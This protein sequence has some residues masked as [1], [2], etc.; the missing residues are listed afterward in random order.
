MAVIVLSHVCAAT[1]AAI[2]PA[3]D[4]HR[5]TLE[6]GS[7]G[8]FAEA[9]RLVL[10]ALAADPQHIPSRRVQDLLADERVGF[11]EDDAATLL[12]KGLALQA[13][14]DW[15]GAASE[16]RKALQRDPTYYLALHNLATALYQ[17][18]DNDKAIAGFRQALEH[19]D[20]YPY[21]HNNLGLAYAR[22]GKH[23]EACAELRRAIDLAP[24][25]Y[26]AYNNLAASVRALGR[27][28]EADEMLRRAL[29]IK[30][31]YA[32]AVANLAPTPDRSAAAGVLSTTALLDALEYGGWDE[33]AG[34]RDELLARRDPESAP[35]LFSLLRNERAEVRAGAARSLAGVGG[36]EASAALSALLSGDP[37]WSVRFE[38]AWALSQLGDERAVEPLGR[39]LA[40]DRDDHVRRNA[41]YALRAFAGCDS[42]RALQGALADP[43]LDVRA[44]ALGSLLAISGQT[45]GSDP[46]RWKGW[47]E[48]VCSPA[49]TAK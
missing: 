37:E 46:A 36:P 23:E 21:T 28:E 49:P 43:V 24:D 16:Y 12:F 19:N 41:A 42:A 1:G 33:R 15:R 27:S 5:K 10:D 11:V 48:S 40:S 4:L 47:V 45:F 26:K 18:G 17:L 29:E 22:A 13:T 44:K 35:R 34:A 9:R 30:A 3:D 31:D 25:Y 39:A 7:R 20:G 2:E 6:A 14:E 32:V 8:D 38:A